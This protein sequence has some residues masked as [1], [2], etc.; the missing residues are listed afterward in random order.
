MGIARWHARLDADA[1]ACGGKRHRC[2]ATRHGRHSAGVRPGGR[3]D[4]IRPAGDDRSRRVFGDVARHHQEPG[5]PP[6]HHQ[7][8]PHRHAALAGLSFLQRA[9]IGLVARDQRRAGGHCGG[10]PGLWRGARHHPGIWHRPDRRSGG[11]FDLPVRAIGTEPCGSSKLDQAPLAHH[12]PRCADL[13]I[14]LCFAAAVRLSR[15]GT[16]RLVCDCRAGRGRNGDALCPASLLPANFRI[17]DVSAIGLILSRVVQ[18]AAALRWPAAIVLLVACVIVVANRDSLWNDKIA[19]LSPVSQADVELDTR[20]RADMGAPDVRYLVVVSGANQEAVLRASER[21][22]TL[23]QTLVEQ[24]ELAGFESPSRYLPSTA[25]QR[26]RQDS[27]PARPVLETRLAQA[28]Q[29]LPVRAQLFTPFL[30]DA[31]AAR[32]QPLLQATDLAAD[33]DGDGGRCLAHS[34]TATMARL[35]AADRARGRQHQRGS[36]SR[37]IERTCPMCCLWT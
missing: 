17:H 15:S 10:Q 1:N 30:D 36:Y 37:G 23:L 31:A 6:V 20:L 3:R 26:A 33:L 19:S 28:V 13:D 35:V 27:L 9:G 18:R 11:L 24:G 32:S 14:R 2:P 34:A 7:P 25:T 4:P 5:H 29:G 8:G 21:V 22:S 12:P 16:T